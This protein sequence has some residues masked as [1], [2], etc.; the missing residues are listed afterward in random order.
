VSSEGNDHTDNNMDNLSLPSTIHPT[1]KIFLQDPETKFLFELLGSNFPKLVQWIDAKYHFLH[2]TSNHAVPKIPDN[3]KE[4]LLVL[5]DHKCGY[6]QKKLHDILEYD[7]IIPKKHW[8]N[9]DIHNLLASCITCHSWKSY[10]ERERDQGCSDEVIKEVL[11]KDGWT[12]DIPIFDLQ[13]NPF[14]N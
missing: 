11:R 7:H 4:V 5:Q 13:A 9:N 8:G 2:T 1:A 12:E 3:Q 10:M 14:V 6:C